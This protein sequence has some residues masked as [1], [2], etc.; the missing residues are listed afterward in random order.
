MG[1][2]FAS[3]DG[4]DAINTVELGHLDLTTD[5]IKLMISSYR[6]ITEDAVVRIGSLCERCSI[7]A[8]PFILRL[9]KLND[10]SDRLSLHNYILTIW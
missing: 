8:T 1:L 2:C 7:D 4:D 10:V 6:D 3:I 5:D 9:F